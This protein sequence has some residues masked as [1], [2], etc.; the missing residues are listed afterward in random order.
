MVTF[1]VWLIT[2]S[3]PP[4]CQ[5][6]VVDLPFTTHSNCTCKYLLKF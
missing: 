6:T 3:T 1:L 2:L 5:L 4:H